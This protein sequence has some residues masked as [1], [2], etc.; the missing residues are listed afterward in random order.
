MGKHDIYIKKKKKSDLS[1]FF[2]MLG[3]YIFLHY[4][5]RATCINLLSLAAIFIFP[6]FLMQAF[7]VGQPAFYATPDL[8]QQQPVREIH[9]K[10]F[11][12]STPRMPFFFLLPP[13]PLL[14]T[15]LFLCL[16]LLSLMSPSR[17]SQGSEKKKR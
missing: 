4:C 5:T 7:T 14:R 1:F 2:F 13:F 9:F 8:L 11:R 17:E 10:Y 12:P 15:V 6:T 16:N 3:L